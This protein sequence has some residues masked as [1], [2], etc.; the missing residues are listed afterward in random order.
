MTEQRVVTVG[1]IEIG[2]EL[3]FVLIAGP[4]QIEVAGARAG[5]GGSAAG[6]VGQVGRAGDLQV[7]LR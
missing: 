2:N 1:G 4:C 7:E 3:P 6:D 5:G